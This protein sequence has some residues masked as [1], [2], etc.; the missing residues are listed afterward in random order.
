[1]GLN[2]PRLKIF[3]PKISYIFSKKAFL[4][5]QQTE[6]SHIFLIKVFLTFQEMELCS[7]KNKKIQEGTS[8]A[9]KI[10]KGHCEKISYISGNRTIF[11]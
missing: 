1:M 7:A 9:R 11:L 6:V 4:T 10:K 3:P 5:Y 8:R 2:N